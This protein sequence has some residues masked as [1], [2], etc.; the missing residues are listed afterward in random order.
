MRGTF[1]PAFWATALAWVVGTGCGGTVVHVDAQGFRFTV[2]GRED[3]ARA[4][5]A[6]AHQDLVIVDSRLVRRGTR[7]HATF[8]DAGPIEPC[9]LLWL[10]DAVGIAVLRA[11]GEPGKT[12]TFASA[13]NVAEGDVVEIPSLIRAPNNHDVVSVDRLATGPDPMILLRGPI[14]NS[15]G[16]VFD[17]VG[18]FLGLLRDVYVVNGTPLGVVTPAW[19]IEPVVQRA[20]AAKPTPLEAARR[21]FEPAGSSLVKVQERSLC[22]ERGQTVAFSLELLN[23]Q[24]YFVTI[25]APGGSY[26]AQVRGQTLRM[27]DGTA[28]AGSGSP[29]NGYE[30]WSPFR[31]CRLGQGACFA[32][33]AS[34]VPLTGTLRADS[35]VNG[36]ATLVVRRMSWQ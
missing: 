27:S 6:V 16:P 1:R 35:D 22:P 31:E 9:D 33:T 8:P 13:G 30:A 5:A 32:V 25:T 3:Q 29:G 7:I 28:G 2:D 34:D 12:L 24:D 36:C 23:D 17:G 10:D 11:H 14:G 19:R 26:T 4:G 21:A 20:L 15:R 18:R